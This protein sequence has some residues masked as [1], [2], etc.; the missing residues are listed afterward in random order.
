MCQLV[1]G[2]IGLTPRCWQSAL[3]CRIRW[4]CQHQFI[5]RPIYAGWVT[6]DQFDHLYV[7]EPTYTRCCTQ[8]RR[9]L[10]KMSKFDLSHMELTCHHPELTWHH[11]ELTMTSHWE[12]A[13]WAHRGVF[14]RIQID[15]TL[16]FIMRSLLACC[17]VT[18]LTRQC[19]HWY[20]KLIIPYSLSS[21]LNQ[22]HTVITQIQKFAN[23]LAYHNIVWVLSF[24][25]C[26]EGMK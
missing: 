2:V 17:E 11:S 16:S 24:I 26:G 7:A 14:I 10:K 21:I 9:E 18:F 8:S 5:F 15:V 4:K 22:H 25:N 23:K 12:V 13:Q 3:V 1:T 20:I 6:S 19:S